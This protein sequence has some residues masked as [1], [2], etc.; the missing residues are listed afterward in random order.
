MHVRQGLNGMLEI[1]KP[2]VM[3]NFKRASHRFISGVIRCSLAGTTT[4]SETTISTHGGQRGKIRKD[5]SA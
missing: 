2:R 1:R 3:V 5:D 4:L